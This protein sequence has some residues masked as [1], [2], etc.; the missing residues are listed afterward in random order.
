VQPV[1]AI[2]EYIP[3]R[4]RDLVR[5][6]DERN[7]P[8]FVRKGYACVR[9]DMRGSGD[10]EG[11]MNDMYSAEELD[12]AVAVIDWI[13]AQPW[14]NGAVGMMGTSWGGTSA[15]RAGSR[16]PAQLKAVIAVCATIDRE[17]AF[18]TTA[19]YQIDPASPV[20]AS[21]RF[22]HKLNIRYCNGEVKAICNARLSGTESHFVCRVMLQIHENGEIVF[23]RRWSVAIERLCG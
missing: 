22:E 5:A 23:E 18:A 9:V 16:L 6:R 17:L 11:L 19:Q 10:S 21:A 20:S 7:H 4:K 3:Y 13:A 12:D 2:L 1:P 14:C 8:Y 15:L